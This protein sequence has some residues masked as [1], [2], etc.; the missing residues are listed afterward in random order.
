MSRL[1]SVLS[2]VALLLV[3]VLAAGSFVLL[4]SEKA[5]ACSSV[6]RFYNADAGTHFYTTSDEEANKIVASYA[7][8][9]TYEGIAY[10]ANVA[11]NFDPLYRFYNKAN[12]SH[13]YTASASEKAAVEATWPGVYTYEGIG[14]NISTTEVA[15]GTTVYRF[16]NKANGSHFYTSSIEERDAVQAR[17]SATYAYEGVAYYVAP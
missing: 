4:G 6:F 2:P 11:T 13:F 16:F 15:G 10:W 14:F 1:R 3:T 9:Y 17:W 7:D 12:G 8:V 5:E